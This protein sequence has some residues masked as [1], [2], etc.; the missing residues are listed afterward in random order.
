MRPTQCNVVDAA[1][2]VTRAPGRSDAQRRRPDVLQHSSKFWITV[3]VQALL[4]EVGGSGRGRPCAV[5]DGLTAYRHVGAP[6]TP[7]R[8]RGAGTWLRTFATAAHRSCNDAETYAAK[9]DALDTRWREQPGRVRA[10][11]AARLLLDLLP[12]VPVITVDSAARL[13]GRSEMRAG[14]PSTVSK[15]PVSCAKATSAGSATAS[16]KQPASSTCSQGSNEPWQA[17]PATG[18]P[19]HRPSGSASGAAC[20]GD[21]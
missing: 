4:M 7:E 5:R 16:S 18:P 21:G 19:P 14:E 20:R 15:P 9:I 12:G 13:I 11:S 6:D 10:N 2:S 1:D 17:Q 3:R 8:S